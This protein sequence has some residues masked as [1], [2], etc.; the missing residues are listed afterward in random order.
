M[1]LLNISHIPL[2]LKHADDDEEEDSISS[3]AG[4]KLILLDSLCYAIQY[5]GLRAKTKNI[6]T[7]C[8]C[9]M[10]LKDQMFY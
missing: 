7:L 1:F 5:G 4:K 9:K 10:E 6:T 2:S 8:L 3:V